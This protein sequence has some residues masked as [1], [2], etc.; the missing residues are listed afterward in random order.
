MSCE[1]LSV[2]SARTRDSLALG[3]WRRRRRLR[4]L[5]AVLDRA[6][7]GHPRPRSAG[8]AQGDWTR[9]LTAA[10]LAVAIVAAVGGTFAH[11]QWGLAVD[12]DGFHLP[13]PLGRPPVVAI[14]VG[15]FDFMR[16]QDASDRPVAYDPCR[17][18]EY[19][20]NDAL[21]PSGAG[22]LIGSAVDEISAATG[23]VFRYV[24][25][26]AEQPRPTPQALLVR[27]RP[28]L[29]AWTTPEVVP[30]LSG[31]IAGVGGSTSRL[32]EYTGQRQYVTGMVALDVT[33]LTEIMARPGGPAQVRAIVLHE[34]GHLVGLDHV[35]DPGELMYAKNVGRLDLGPGDREGLAALGS[36]RCFH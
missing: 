12:T 5:L 28:V 24:G 4:R 32:D 31:D 18:I 33:Q 14:G 11:K 15:S 23:L 30:D 6:D 26:T 9:R 1:P 3:P 21:A 25:E 13:S 16:T 10:F 2:F 19:A 27:R 36:G 22:E 20:V 7:R 35:D 29:I 8:R 17:P 34:L